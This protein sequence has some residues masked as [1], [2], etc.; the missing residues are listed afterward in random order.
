[1]K[2]QFLVD[3]AVLHARNNILIKFFFQYFYK[4]NVKKILIIKYENFFINPRLFKK[5]KFD[6]VVL[7]AVDKINIHNNLNFYKKKLPNFFFSVNC[8]YFLNYNLYDLQNKYKHNPKKFLYFNNKTHSIGLHLFDKNKINFYKEIEAK[9]FKN[10]CCVKIQYSKSDLLELDKNV[11][12]KKINKFFTQINSKNIIF[13]RDG[14]INENLGYVGSIKNF[15]WCQGAIA[16]IKYFN[17]KKYNIFI[18]TNQSGVARGFF[19]E[20]KVKI[21]HQF[22]KDQLSKNHC[23]INQIYYCPFHPQAKIKK[24]KRD[25]INRKPKIGLFLQIKKNWFINNKNTYMIGDQYSDMEFAKN[26]KIKGFL[27]NEKNL[28]KFVKKYF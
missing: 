4:Y 19:S 21:L 18:V 14:V 23:Y 24:Y 5:Y 26:C 28:F 20:K 10:K 13:D 8:N 17:K 2:D 1:M 3:Y 7:K 11:S 27:F 16:A 22:I 6:Y 9:H 12:Q 25:S 15:K